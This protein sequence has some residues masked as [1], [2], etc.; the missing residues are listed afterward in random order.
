MRN[1]LLKVVLLVFCALLWVR[2]AQAF[3]FVVSDIQVDGLQRVS[4]GTVFSA[5]P[6]NIGDKV[7]EVSLASAIRTLFH[8]GLFKN[9]SVDRDKDV[10]IIH[11]KER[12]AIAKINIKGNKAIDTDKLKEGLKNAGLQE[13]Q[14]FKR[15]TLEKLQMEILRSYVGQGRYNARVKG[16]VKDLKRNRV[17]ITL[18]ISEGKTAAIHHINIVGNKA[19]SDDEL[20]DLFELKTSDWWTSLFNDD[21]YSRE[22]LSGDLEKLRS[23]YLDHGYIKFS[24][25]STQVSLSPDK[26]QVFITVAITEGPQYKIRDVHIKG[27]TILPRKD[28]RKL[29]LIKPGE[30]FS[31]QKLTAT[32]DLISKRL[33]VEGYT[34]AN[35]NAVPETHDDHTATV[36][37]YV[38][39]GRRVYVHRINFTGN[40]VTKDS[41]LRQEMLQMEGAVAST[42]LIDQSKTRLERLGFFKSVNV[43]T[44]S[45]PGKSD[46]IDVNYSVEEQPTGSLSASL[47]YSQLDGAL[48]GASVS[49]KNWMGTGRQVS[50]GANVSKSVKS[51]NFSYLN[52]YY[53][54]DG[55]SRGFSLFTR[56]TD[57]SAQN[58]TITSY[59]LD[60][61]GANL[62]F[63]YP[64]DNVTRLNF[65]LGYSHPSVKIGDLPAQEISQFIGQYGSN[66]NIYSLNTSWVRNTLNRGVYP[67]RGYSHAISANL[68]A[69][70]SDLE[71]Y[72][73]T[74]TFKYFIPLNQNQNWVVKLRTDVGYGGGYGKNHSLPFFEHF[75]SGGYGSVRGYQANS[76]GPTATPAL[77]DASTPPPFGGNVLTEGTAALIFPLP[78]VKD[79]HSMRSSLFFDA[80]NVFDTDRGYNPKLNALRMSLGVNFQWLTAIGPL[81]FSLAKPLNSKPGDH[82]QVF[83]FTLG[84]QF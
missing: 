6:I 25:D 82:T 60:N 13:G 80:G 37:F 57:Y 62:S 45:V 31:R 26:K 29:V 28:I 74:D 18:K 38:D 70:G 23:F 65:G 40:T 56:K 67:T 2:Q 42:D 14:I 83:Q 39:P 76:L 73:L 46:Q 58:V 64:L 51:A 63:G 35:V 34:F 7:D 17:D 69:P 59:T 66:Y 8:T 78:F 1:S 52:P 20:R 79:Q 72:K 43:E 61:Y 36:T 27:K 84:Q 32:T 24:I 19:F 12:P 54:V 50:L 71:Y 21:K 16:E 3:Q 53:T 15:S 49:E 44:P 33:G 68:S 47:G 77:G 41:V 30:V 9:I 11:V 10:L 55:V 22:K 4:A 5:F 81:G 48:V 75:F